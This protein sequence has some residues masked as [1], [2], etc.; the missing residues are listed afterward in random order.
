[1]LMWQYI[2]HITFDNYSE[3]QKGLPQNFKY[4]WVHIDD[5]LPTL[6]ESTP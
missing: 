6:C 1:M 4:E 3:D 2:E 5:K